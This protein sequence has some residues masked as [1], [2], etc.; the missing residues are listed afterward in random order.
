MSAKQ[1]VEIVKSYMEARRHGNLEHA[2]ELLSDDVTHRFMFEIPGV[3]SEWR[4]KEGIEEFTAHVKKMF[5]GGSKA[6]IKR[7]HATDDSVVVESVNSGT[8]HNGKPYSNKYCFIYEI[9]ND[10]IKAIRE[11]TDSHYSIENLT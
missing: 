11:Y 1:N 8:A 9:K 6:E 4:G 2:L 10:K 3:P 5:P 7:I